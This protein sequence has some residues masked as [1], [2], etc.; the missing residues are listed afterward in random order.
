MDLSETEVCRYTSQIKL[1]EIGLEGQRKLKSA[2]VAVVGA[3]GL[4]CAAL[5]YLAAAGIGRIGIIDPDRIELGNLQRQILYHSEDIGRLKGEA[6][7][8]RLSMLNP[9][10]AFAAKAVF[11]TEYNAQ[12]LLQDYDVVIDAT[13]NF[14]A[15]YAI[16][17][18]CLALCK[19]FVY[20]S[21]S[22]FEGQAAL[23]H[24]KPD[25]RS[26][27]PVPP[28]QGSSCAAAGVI[29][30]LPG[31]IGTIQALEA[32]KVILDAGQ[33]LKGKLLKIDALSWTTRLYQIGPPQENSLEI[34]AERVRQMLSEKV[35]LQLIDAR[36]EIQV[37]KG[38]VTILY[39]E[40]G[41]RSLQAAKLLKER[42]PLLEIYTLKGG[43]SSFQREK[44]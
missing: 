39:C 44:K 41:I 31:M 42:F 2:S 43:I 25:Y 5:L 24:G 9:H 18:A 3:G 33:T 4:G 6:A 29:A 22:H 15:R 17:D 40:R 1:C 32:M 7:K 21:I 13:D 14:P 19:P 34:S 16:N 12:E 8:E 36:E 27:Y 10:V 37:P 35:D 28:V 30:P 20:G 38:K 11:L 26:L 23:F